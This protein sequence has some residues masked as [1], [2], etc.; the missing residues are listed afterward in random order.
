MKELTALA[1]SAR[2]AARMIERTQRKVAEETHT[3]LL[4]LLDMVEGKR[5]FNRP[6]LR[7][8]GIRRKLIYLD[9]ES[10]TGECK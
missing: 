9:V 6:V 5:D 7:Y 1:V 8:L 2:L 3:P 10:D 4:A